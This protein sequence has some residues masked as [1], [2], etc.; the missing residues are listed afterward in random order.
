MN[1]TSKMTSQLTEVVLFVLGFST[2]VMT[3]QGIFSCIFCWEHFIITFFWKKVF[4][5]VFI[6]FCLIDRSHSFHLFSFL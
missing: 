4:C 5:E 1:T 6:D 2:D 3:V